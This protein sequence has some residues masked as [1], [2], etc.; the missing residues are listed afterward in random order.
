MEPQSCAVTNF[1]NKNLSARVLNESHKETEALIFSRKC[2]E[3]QSILNDGFLLLQSLF[4][5]CFFPP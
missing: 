5:V 1:V 2:K 3:P 4:C